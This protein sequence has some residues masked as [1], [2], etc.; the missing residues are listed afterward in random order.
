M[1]IKTKILSLSAAFA[2]GLAGLTGLGVNSIL[3]YGKMADT[4]DRTHVHAFLGEQ[5]NGIVTSIVADSRGIYA[6]PDTKTAGNYAKGIRQ[7]LDEMN[8][9]LAAWDGIAD[10][11]DKAEL[12]EVKDQAAEFTK[13]RTE[14][15]RLGSEVSPVEANTFGNNDENR[16]NRK[17]FQARID[18]LV[19]QNRADLA[20]QQDVM[21]AFSRQRVTTFA[22]LAGAGSALL[23]IYSLWLSIFAVSRPLDRVA[24]VVGKIADG[25]YQTEI[26]AVSGRDEIANL[27]R[28][29]GKLR[30]KAL[31]AEQ[32]KAEQEVNDA[33]AAQELILERNRIA[34]R[35]QSSMGKLAEDF[36][37]VSKEVASSAEN[38]SATA[39]ETSRQA[40]AVT[41]A[42]EEA[43]LNVEG[44]ASATEEMTG[45]VQEINS[46]VTRSA[47]VALTATEEASRT[48]AQIRE[49]SAAAAQIGD[50]VNLISAIA[51]QT[52]LLAL[53]ATIE[54]ARA[55]EAG[56]GFAVVASEVKNLAGQTAK[57]TEE[58]S[59]KVDEIQ[60]ATSATVGSIE[61]I[62]STISTIRDLTTA[63]AGSV[64]QQGHATSEIANNT[65]RASVGTHEV[66]QN[67]H[68]VGHAAEQTGAA[69]TQLMQLSSGLQGR[70]SDLEREV[71]IF[72]RTLRAG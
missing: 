17:A 29:T 42:A 7:S 63:I 34:D 15:A 41:G 3:S 46:Q 50:V 56:K 53:N 2:L 40:Q 64:E 25:A 51:G 70:A 26:P 10:E 39:E 9:L 12:A 57:A 5:L 19:E 72:V 69:A 8:K 31:E 21:R 59:K 37:S 18:A 28:A 49:L 62:V 11:S 65:Q 32:L 48:E 44:V 23:L 14:L 68:G 16:A 13:F 61:T 67:I 30:D 58:I 71:E 4:L 38:L 45:S 22:L 47:A 36:V 52:N 66:T 43:A 55:G 24:G 33:K 20:T 54:A 60:A 27:W 35:F 1:R 6:A